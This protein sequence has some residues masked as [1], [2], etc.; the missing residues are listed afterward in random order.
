M[1]S[2]GASKMDDDENNTTEVVIWPKPGKGSQ[3]LIH[4]GTRTEKDPALLTCEGECG[5]EQ[6]KWTL[7]HVVSSANFQCQRCGNCRRWGLSF[8]H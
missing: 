6:I 7:H 4:V 2:T 8:G 5:K 1:R 3:K